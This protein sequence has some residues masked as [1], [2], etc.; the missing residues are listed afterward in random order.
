[1]SGTIKTAW[2]L[3][4]IEKKEKRDKRKGDPGLDQLFGRIQVDLYELFRMITLYSENIGDYTEKD[5]IS[6]CADTGYDSMQLAYETRLL[7]LKSK[8]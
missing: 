5:I 2:F 6:K 1:M 8:K 7:F 4:E 3:N